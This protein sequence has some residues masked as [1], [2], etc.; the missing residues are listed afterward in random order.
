[1]AIGIAHIYSSA[2]D[3]ACRNVNAATLLSDV[4][5][6]VV[7]LTNGRKYVAVFV[8]YERLSTIWQ[9]HQLSGAYLSGTYYWMKN[10]VLVKN[11]K[12]KTVR[13]VVEYLLDEGMFWE[14]FEEL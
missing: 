10:M 5:D 14:T 12:M 1:M 4:S 9:K 11:C 7:S 2:E 6:I 13:K 8:S 3:K